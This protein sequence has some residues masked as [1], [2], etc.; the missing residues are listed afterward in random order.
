M[1]EEKLLVQH[2]LRKTR[3]RILVLREFSSQDKALAH[4]E[5]Q[6][7]LS[8]KIDR[9]TLYRILEQFEKKG[10]LH[11]IPDD[12]VSV[13]YALCTHHHEIDHKHSDDHAHFK[14]SNCSDTFCIE[15][16]SIPEF[17]PPKGFTVTEKFLILGGLCAKCA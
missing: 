16:F 5:L 17:K 1:I 8:G 2:N 7:S 13:K 9:V 10:I 15:E 3:S 14:C 4:N 11:K 12:E 6:Q